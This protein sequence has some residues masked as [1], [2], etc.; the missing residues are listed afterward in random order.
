MVKHI[1]LFIGITVFIIQSNALTQD[2][3]S[4]EKTLI[5]EDSTSILARDAK[6]FVQIGFGLFNAP[7]DFKA[8][9]WQRCGMVTAS[10]ALLFFIDKD[11]KRF[12]LNNQN[13]RNDRLFDVDQ[14]HGNIYTAFLASGTYGLGYFINND[15]IRLMGLHSMEA[16]VYSGIV[17]SF[18][19]TILRRRRPYGGESN[20]IFKPFHLKTLYTALPSGHTTLSF[21][22]STVMAKS[23]NNFL[24]KSF[25]YGSAGMVAASRIYHNKHWVSDVFL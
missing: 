2:I 13:Q 14:Y 5:Y 1:F 3:K 7:F 21:A 9:E 4:P 16:F 17:S 22:V 10:T 24:W 8:K 25:W 18:F 6:H 11:V 19:N 20:L 15:K 12:A 23:Y